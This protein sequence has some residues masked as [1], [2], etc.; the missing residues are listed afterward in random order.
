[1][2]EK[3][4]GFKPVGEHILK[5]EG[6]IIR[7]FCST[8]DILQMVHPV[9][10]G[11]CKVRRNGCVHPSWQIGDVHISD[12]RVLEITD[13]ESEHGSHASKQCPSKTERVLRL[14]VDMED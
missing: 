10:T 4:D 12:S 7:Q 3:A 8:V 5:E 11:V 13:V 9:A 14:N 6:H 2:G 1:M